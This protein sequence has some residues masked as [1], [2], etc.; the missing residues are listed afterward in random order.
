MNII[1]PAWFDEPGFTWENLP[2]NARIAARWVHA[3]AKVFPCHSRVF[4]DQR[5]NIHEVKTPKTPRGFKDA[6][7]NLHRVL[8]WWTDNP[9]D[10]VGVPCEEQLVIIDIDMDPDKEEPVDGWASLLELGLS[11]PE[12]FMALTPRGGNHSYC[13]TP[14]GFLPNSVKNLRLENGTVLDGVDRRARGG[15]FIAWSEDA[16]PDAIS[17]LPVAPVEFCH[18]Y[19]GESQGVEFS[20]SVEEWLATIGA[21]TP[22]GPMK[23]AKPKIPSGEFGH[24]EMRDLQ[25]HII[26]LA[27]EGNPG[28]AEVLDLLRSEYLRPP[29]DTLYFEADYNAALGGGVKKYGGLSDSQSTNSAGSLAV[30]AVN[31]A[32]ETYDFFPTLDGDILA[33]PKEGPK[34]ALSLDASKDFQLQLSDDFFEAH[35]GNK[36]LSDKA[37][38]EAVGIIGGRY[39]KLP[40]VEAHLRV[41]ELDGDTYL[42]LGDETGRCVRI[43]ADGWSVEDESPVLFR[44]T[45]LIAPLPVPERGND[46]KEFFNLIN[47]PANRKPVYLG[48]LVS[49]YFPNIAHPIL[50]PLGPQGSGKSKASEHTHRLLDPSPIFG[51]KLPRSSDEWVI[52]AQASYVI[53]LDNVSRLNEEMS[54]ALCRASTGDAALHRKLYSN[55]DVEIFEFRRVVILNGIDILGIREDLADRLLV[56]EMQAISP[57]KRLTES[58]M[59][60]AA[61]DMLP[62]VLGA[63]LDV[64]V[65]VKKTLPHVYL[66]KLPRMADFARILKA[67]EMI[68]PGLNALAEYELGIEEAA[69]NAIQ[70]NPVLSAMVEIITEPWEGTSKDLLEVLNSQKPLFDESRKYWPHTPV[71]MTSVLARSGPAFT[72]IGWTVEDLGSRNKEKTKRWRL[73]P[74]QPSTPITSPASVNDQSLGH[75]L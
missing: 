10:L 36:V 65:E 58:S 24:E 2:V 51:R 42:D 63:L 15:Y 4:E 6:C 48:F 73:S 22:I 34:V 19:S 11:V 3:G 56:M 28:A 45:K 44:R 16:I 41:A 69:M 50:A 21:G 70:Q 23:S 25:R 55:K 29:Y 13:R 40:K 17:Q 66:E 5:G 18:L 72:K 14:E 31:I 74:P 57:E 32:S 46:L 30:A 8:M 75:Q 71:L 33:V 67:L 1:P 68:Y 43:T 12:D 53:T 7:D 54:D 49:F 35:D 39:Y 62:G 27:S 20:K 52:T 61:A 9:E 60:T 26:G 38:K 59:D 47:I 37:Y 64:V